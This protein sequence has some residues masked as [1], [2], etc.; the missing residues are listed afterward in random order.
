MGDILRNM[1]MI[2]KG[3]SYD[4]ELKQFVKDE[5]LK[6]EFDMEEFSPKCGKCNNILIKKYKYCPYCGCKIKWE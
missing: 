5:N 1:E 3:Y 4:P 6:N 2:Q